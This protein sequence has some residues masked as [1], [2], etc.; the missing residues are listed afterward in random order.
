LIFPSLSLSPHPLPPLSISLFLSPEVI[1]DAFNGGMMLQPDKV[2]ERGK[3]NQNF[4]RR[5]I[6]I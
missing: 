4:K 3:E 5:G 2:R 1:V 6:Y